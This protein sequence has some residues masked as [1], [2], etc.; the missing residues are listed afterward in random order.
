MLDECELLQLDQS[1]VFVAGPRTFPFKT[2]TWISFYWC[3]TRKWHLARFLL[4]H[5]C[6]LTHLTPP[7]I[8]LG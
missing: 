4:F 8:T 6:V 5:Y 7:S 3:H 2:E 1:E